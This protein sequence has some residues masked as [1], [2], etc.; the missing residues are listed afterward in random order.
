M[1]SDP[2]HDGD[3]S[4]TVHIHLQILDQ[5]KTVTLNVP[6]GNRPIGDVLPIARQLSEQLTAV[7]VETAAGEGRQI[8]CRAGCGACC[9]QLVVISLPEAIALADVVAAMPAERQAMVR[10][11]FT[12]ALA[13]LEASGLLEPKQP[14][15]ERYLTQ[16]T[17][18]GRTAATPLAQRYFQQK[19]ACPLLEDESC[20][21]YADRPLVC[22]EYLVTSPAEDC[23]RL[24]EVPVERIELP[25]RM[26]N[27]MVQFAHRVGG[28]PCE[29]IPL[30]LALEWAASRREEL[31]KL[32]SGLDLVAELVTE[33]AAEQRRNA[34]SEP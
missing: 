9:R 25:V 28:M 32:R 22:R 20:G 18:A 10:R 27:V 12:E 6:P 29:S 5:Q 2:P 21:I 8:S 3:D 33:T 13:R 24:F 17:A 26:G 19:I 15:R 14:D 23:A 7:G 1:G 31:N 34:E 16:P 11:R 4:Q 30:V